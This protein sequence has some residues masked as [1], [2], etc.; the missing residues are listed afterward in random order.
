MDYTDPASLEYALHGVDLVISTVSGP[1]QINLIT[2]AGKGTVRHFVPAEFEGKLSARGR[3]SSVDPLRP[4]SMSPQA[5]ELLKR[6]EGRGRMKYTVFTCGILM[7]TFHPSG[8][9]HFNMGAGMGVANPG[10]YILNINTATATYTHRD[11]SNHRVY[12]SLTSAYDL[13]RFIVAALALRPSHWPTEFTLRG[14]RLSI[15][16]L[17]NTCSHLQNGKCTPYPSPPPL[18]SQIY[19]Q[20]FRDFMLNAACAVTFSHNRCTIQDLPAFIDYA[21]QTGETEQAAFYQR[22]LA[23]ANGRFDFSRATLNSRIAD[24]QAVDFTPMTFSRWL[25]QILY[26]TPTA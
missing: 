24:R 17:V 7:E 5:L 6:I 20:L 19:P 3:S 4:N 22:L 13:A 1:E 25:T 15:E 11:A 9:G 18:L 2:A 26:P 21:A 23:T 16:E 14:D 10:D 12:I 8:L